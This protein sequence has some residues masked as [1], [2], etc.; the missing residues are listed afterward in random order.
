MSN[1][2]N[3]TMGPF[4]WLLLL[5]LS[6]LWGGSFFF[7]KLAIAELPPFSLVLGRVGL[8]A[9]ILHLIVVLKGDRFP[10][11][12]RILGSFLAMGVLNNL[13]PFSLIF[14]SQTQIPSGLASILNATTPLWTVVLAHFLTQDEK[15]TIP[16][17]SGLLL[18]LIG[19]IVM[20]EPHALGG[21]G[22]NAMAQL[23]VLAAAFS[24]ALAA[25]FGRRFKGIP[26]LVTAAGQLTGTAL[27]MLPIA[28][29]VDKPWIFLPLSPV[30][31][32]SVLGLALFCTAIAYII[33][34]RIL[35]AAGATNL[36]L[37]TLLIPVSAILLGH[38]ILG[39]RLEPR[40][41]LGL[42]LIGAGLAAIDGRILD[43]RRRLFPGRTDGKQATPDYFQGRD[44]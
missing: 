13:I 32:G 34:F 40:H 25:I 12:P 5:T 18:G 37:V 16:R 21:L 7:G 43:F 9:M 17:L 15:I 23:A 29:I 26:P 39:E 3:K 31:W 4:E 6:A 8:A 30:T 24:Y 33:Y 27:M 35:A 19:V 2:V 41:F 11:D 44:I 28:F 10:R 36:L 42:V 1:V 14:W 22:L 38:F 20:V